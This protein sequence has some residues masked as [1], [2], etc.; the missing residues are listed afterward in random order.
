M[1]RLGAGPPQF[2]STG[3]GGDQ[4]CRA[5]RKPCGLARREWQ[6]RSNI[7]GSCARWSSSRRWVVVELHR[8]AHADLR[9]VMI[10]GLCNGA[11]YALI[12]LGYTLVYGII[13]LI[14][15][16]HG[17]LFMLGTVF[18][19]FMIADVAR[20]ETSNPAGL[21]GIRD[22]L[23]SLAMAF[24]AI[25]Q[26]RDR[27]ARLP[28]AAQGAQAG[29]ADHRGRRVSFIFQNIGILWN[30]SAPKSRNS[31]AA[32]AAAS[33]SARSRSAWTYRSSSSRIT[34][35]L[36]LLLT[37]I[38]QKTRGQG[39]ARDGAGPG[40]RAADGHQ[41]RPDHLLHVRPRRRHGRGGR[42]SCTCRPTARRATTPA[43][44]SA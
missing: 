22:H 19:A 15:F 43:S 17:D 24:C 44:S 37:W 23:R 36:L 9:Q 40:R 8:R 2:H 6:R 7:T 26:R 20:P 14:N 13:E 42:R 10:L 21:A 3:R 12:A 5:L 39:D 11:L 28:P 35:P 32:A 29:A 27:A 16:A 4:E 25:D 33:P 41:R 18:A 1:V 34:I 38:V 31:R 30:G